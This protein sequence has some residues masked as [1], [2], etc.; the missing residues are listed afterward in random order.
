MS[1]RE[2]CIATVVHM[3]VVK[4][5]N[6]LHSWLTGT[7]R[8]GR[9][10]RSLRTGVTDQ[11]RPL[12]VGIGLIYQGA[13]ERHRRS[14]PGKDRME[15]DHSPQ[16]G[17]VAPKTSRDRL[18]NTL[19]N[20]GTALSSRTAS[21]SQGSVWTGYQRHTRLK[22]SISV[23]ASAALRSVSFAQLLMCFCLVT[24]CDL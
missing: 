11:R 9:R 2:R 23:A 10:S 4:D 1:S 13:I 21:T 24:M 16:T 14:V 8:P 22:K 6:D 17:A 19:G 15:R 12:V 7:Q 18:S 20:S 3:C 5:N